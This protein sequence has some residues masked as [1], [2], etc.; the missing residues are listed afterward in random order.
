MRAEFYS[1]ATVKLLE[2]GNSFDSVLNKLTDLL[3]K[4]NKEKLLP[5]I[6]SHMQ[7]DI[8]AYEKSREIVVR[9][10]DR[11]DYAQYQDDI[12]ESLRVL[13][14]QDGDE[15]IAED[16]TIVGGYSVTA[17]DKV[18]DRTYKKKLLTIYQSVIH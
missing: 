17:Y 14:A 15:H 5:S 10:K 1:K 2:E 3:R 11:H 4:Q 13:G 9:I 16:E 6:L 18:V 12:R 7:K 8:E